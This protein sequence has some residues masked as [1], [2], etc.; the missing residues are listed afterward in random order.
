MKD[1]HLYS[2]A[3]PING[4]QYS[5]GY[6]LIDDEYSIWAI[7]TENIGAMPN[8]DFVNKKALRDGLSVTIQ[9]FSP[10]TVY[11][12]A[13]DV[14]HPMLEIGRLKPKIRQVAQ[15]QNLKLAKNHRT[16][17]QDI[18]CGIV[19]QFSISGWEY[20][21]GKTHA[22]NGSTFTVYTDGSYKPDEESSSIGV[23]VCDSKNRVVDLYNHQLD[24]VR[25][26]LHSE[27][28]A[29]LIALNRLNMVAPK[30]KVTLCTDN[31]TVYHCFERE[32][33][34]T[35]N[36][37]YDVVKDIEAFRKIR[38]SFKV[39]HVPREEN[40]LA[41]ALAYIA[42]KQEVELYSPF[43]NLF[44]ENNRKKVMSD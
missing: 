31:Q 42:H 34:N 2:K 1:L 15:K 20:I 28:K 13:P 38:S 12:H 14:N 10:N 30:D 37:I 18:L 5:K 22:D 35:P 19:E 24:E 41:D 4:G 6:L 7:G 43:E 21:K 40:T 9:D 26:S 16:H 3:I 39:K 33:I 23:V 44:S 32:D 36:R 25:D 11:I 27:F 17:C 8:Y 29:V